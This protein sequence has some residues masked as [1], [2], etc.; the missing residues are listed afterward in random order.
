MYTI[1]DIYLT[2]LNWQV[3]N[4][5]PS[6]ENHVFHKCNPLFFFTGKPLK[7]AESSE[8]ALVCGTSGC[9]LSRNLFLYL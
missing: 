6:T 5:Q 2:A 4:T 7:I 9:L 1:K 8:S 3:P